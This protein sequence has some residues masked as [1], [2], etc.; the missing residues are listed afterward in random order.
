V[1][2][3]NELMK[4]YGVH[5]VTARDALGLLRNSGLVEAKA[6]VGTFVRSFA[7]IYR[8]GSRRLRSE[9]WTTGRTIQTAELGDRALDVDLIE[10][11][12]LPAD[13]RMANLLELAPGEPLV[14]RQRRY[15]VDGKPVQR[16]V[17]YLPASVATGTRIVEDDPGP[18]GIYGRLAELGQGP[19]R[20]VEEL[21]VRMPNPDETRTLE[22]GPGTPVVIMTRLA[23]T[24]EDRPIEVSEMTFDASAYSFVYDIED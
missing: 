8:Y 5:R 17:A 24:A 14:R 12:T 18:G 1:P 20:W 22:L 15:R 23:Y 9:R 11:D 2:G 7:P 21:S 19:V 13:D 4:R 10:V 16:A 6:K 3:E